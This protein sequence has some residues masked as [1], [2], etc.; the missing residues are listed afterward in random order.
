MID[1]ASRPVRYRSVHDVIHDHYVRV[2]SAQRSTVAHVADD[3]IAHAVCGALP[4][5][6]LW[7]GTGSHDEREHADGL[8]LCGECA[9]TLR[10]AFR[11]GG[12]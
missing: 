2:Y 5:G 6:E 1:S 4:A 8:H 10:V 11:I 3:Y 9:R 7:L 12:A